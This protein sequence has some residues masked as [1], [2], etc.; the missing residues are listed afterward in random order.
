[1]TVLES[2]SI[3][4]KMF[5][6]ASD[7]L[8]LVSDID[9]DL[10]FEAVN[11]AAADI[12]DATRDEMLGTEVGDVLTEKTRRRL[13]PVYREAME[14]GESSELTATLE[15][16]GSERIARFRMQRLDSSHDQTQLFVIVQDVTELA[17]VRR[18]LDADR[19][20][21]RALYE[22]AGNTELDLSEKMRRLL[23]IGCERLELPVGFV[24]DIDENIQ[25]ILQ[26][27]GEH[28]AIVEGGKAPLDESYCRKTLEA[29][30]LVTYLN[31]EEEG[32]AG[33][34]AFERYQLACYI[35]AKLHV[36]GRLV[37]TVCFADDR[38][39]DREFSEGERTFVQLLAQW[40][41]RELELEHDFRSVERAARTDSLTGLANH[42]EI[43]DR[44]ED[45]FRGARREDSALALVL[46]DLD[47]F[48]DLNDEYGHL[49]GDNVLEA[50]GAL[51]DESTRGTDVA[52]R[53]G[54]EEFVVV[55]PR[56]ELAEAKH[57]AKRILKGVRNLEIDADGDP[58]GVTCSAGMATLQ[59][60]DGDMT[61]LLSRA[62][63]ALYRAKGR[64]RDR[65]VAAT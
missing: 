45:E 61:D 8:V 34:P 24:T 31:A 55:M 14:S 48:K 53:Y 49:V 12:F 40:V 20:A 10:V 27:V 13:E 50:I 38:A 37:G 18:A 39:R 44:L 41:G 4:E 5:R 62:D 15:E 54:G 25:R 21:M 58:V 51:L 29:D 7:G 52:G 46:F 23:E 9:G 35:G 28:D 1:M 59:E 16:N 26:A 57:V 60:S 3:Y 64:G 32:M 43:I 19:R 17:E 30:G 6:G 22:V 2:N 56:T 36:A 63:R 11:T 47:H 33:D 65:V 42:G